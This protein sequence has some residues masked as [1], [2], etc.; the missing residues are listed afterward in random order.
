MLI[1]IDVFFGKKYK[2]EF[3]YKEK[4]ELVWYILFG[5]ALIFILVGF[6]YDI[7]M[8]VR[9]QIASVIYPVIYFVICFALVILSFF[10]F[11]FREQ[12]FLLII[13]DVNNTIV[14]E[15][16]EENKEINDKN[17]NDNNNINNDNNKEEAK[18]EANKSKTD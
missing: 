15:K 5:L 17:Q 3:N 8:I 18:N 4:F 13:D 1:I 11:I 16:S 9:G 6:F 2:I 12:Y 7:A 10:D 14:P